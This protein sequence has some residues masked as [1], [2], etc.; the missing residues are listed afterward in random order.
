M[1][2]PFE[3]AALRWAVPVDVLKAVAYVETGFTAA[4]GDVEFEG[5]PAPWGY[6]NLRGEALADGASLIGVSVEAVQADASLGIEAAAALLDQ[7]AI[8]VDLPDERRG[9]PAQWGPALQRYGD[10]DDDLAADFA[11]DVLDVI[12]AGVAVPMSDGG[13]VVVRRHEMALGDR[14]ASQVAQSTSGLGAGG[15][16]WRPSPNHSS[17]RGNRVEMVIIHT[18]EGGYAGCVSWLRNTR[19]RASAHYVVKEDGRETSQL[20]DENRRA[21]HVAAS[22]RR[23]LNDGKLPGR[24]GQSVNDFSIGIEHGGSARQR[25]FPQGQL[26][27]S[28]RLVRDITGRHNIPRDRYHIVG[29]GQLQPES[30]TDPGPSWPWSSYLRAINQGAA[31][32][33]PSNPPP[34][35]APPPAPSPSVITVDNSTPGRFRASSRWQTSRWA[36]GRV[37]ADYRYRAAAFTSDPA[38]YKVPIRAA[39]RYEVFARIPGNGYNTKVPYI[40]HHAGGKSVVHR[41]VNRD[42]A[43]WVSLGTYRFDAKDDWIVQLSCWT[44]GDG[45]IIADA[46]KLERR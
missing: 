21:W 6:F 19:A 43:K 45:W 42:G 3:A 9:D 26:D 20:V 29:H 35:T 40:I 46:I 37:G 4:E 18:C 15:T 25:S 8:E 12:N 24:Q 39:G 2:A 17:R 5:Q 11:R 38:S 16:V 14:R 41:N 10:H 30:R 28:V 23:H 22:Y 44:N 31:T 32:P 36:S 34:A 33:P 7:R 13:N 27:A 1:A